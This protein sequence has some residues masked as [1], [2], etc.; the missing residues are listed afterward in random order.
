MSGC[1]RAIAALRLGSLASKAES[2]GSKS[3]SLS[4]AYRRIY[5]VKIN[6]LQ[7]EFLSESSR[8]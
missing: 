1:S 7:L 8:L 6:Q 3:S 2:V 4:E 5:Q